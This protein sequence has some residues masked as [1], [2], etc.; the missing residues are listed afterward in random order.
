MAVM[1]N[2][3]GQRMAFERAPRTPIATNSVG[4]AGIKCCWGGIELDQGS[5]E[6]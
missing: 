6:S 3:M 2:V 4:M 1:M 5:G